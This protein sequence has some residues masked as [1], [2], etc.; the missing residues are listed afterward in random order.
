MVRGGGCRPE[1][2]AGCHRAEPGRAAA[3]SFRPAPN[4]LRLRVARSGPGP[5]ERA[6]GG[7]PHRR[8]SVRSGLR[9]GGAGG[10]ALTAR[11][12]PV[13]CLRA[14]SGREEPGCR[15]RGAPRGPGEGNPRV[16]LRS[17][18]CEGRPPARGGGWRGMSGVSCALEVSRGSWR[19]CCPCGE[20]RGCRKPTA[21]W[22]VD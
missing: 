5:G 2:E 8:Y 14:S 10:A 3:V 4:V 16:A 12:G 1:R 13:R 6:A 11:P 17:S 18:L 15:Q 19:W 22:K 7:R 21:A 20:L 9:K